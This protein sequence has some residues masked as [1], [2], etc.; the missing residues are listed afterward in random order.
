MLGLDASPTAPETTSVPWTEAKTCSFT[1]V[2]PAEGTTAKQCCTPVRDLELCLETVS[3][4]HHHEVASY[5]KR[6]LLLIRRSDEEVVVRFP[7]DRHHH[8]SMKYADTASVLLAFR[9]HPRGLDVSLRRGAGC[10]SP[11]VAA[12]TCA[13][14]AK[15]VAEI[16]ESVGA[17]VWDGRHLLRVPTAE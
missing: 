11:C 8:G 13:G 2:S 10:K 4:I 16:C 9:V 5:T 1:A 7:L 3:T 15:R 12:H 14:E 6:T 17:Y